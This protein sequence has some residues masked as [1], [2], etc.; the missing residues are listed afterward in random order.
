MVSWLGLGLGLGETR[1]VTILRGRRSGNLRFFE[2][3]EKA[4]DN[5]CRCG[6]FA[7]FVLRVV[8]THQ[9]LSF[10]SGGR[11]LV[12]ACVRTPVWWSDDLAIFAVSA[13]FSPT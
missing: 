12:F 7:C 1:N 4:V 6:P 5:G 3:S 11:V 8:G 10:F 13:V 2:E 9:Y